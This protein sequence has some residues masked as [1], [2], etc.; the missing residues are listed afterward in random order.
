MRMEVNKDDIRIYPEGH[1]DRAYIKHVLGMAAAGEG[2]VAA[3]C[4]VTLGLNSQ[5]E[6]NCIRLTRKEASA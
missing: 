3:R 5:S 6:M 1:A 4:D 2:C